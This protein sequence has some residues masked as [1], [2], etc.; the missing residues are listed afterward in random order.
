M[1]YERKIDIMVAAFCAAQGD[2]GE[3]WEAGIRKGLIDGFLRIRRLEMAEGAAEARCCFFPVERIQEGFGIWSGTAAG[4]TAGMGLADRWQRP[5]WT[6][7]SC[8]RSGMWRRGMAAIPW[9]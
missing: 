2:Q 7:R 3:A 6:G 5:E 1:T 9:P 8:G 4:M